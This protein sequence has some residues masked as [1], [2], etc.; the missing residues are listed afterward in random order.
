MQLR[1]IIDHLEKWAPPSLQEN[2]DNSGLILGDKN[3]ECHSAIVSLDVTEEVVDEAIESQ[4]D[5]II[6]HHPLIF[7]GKKRI[8]KTHW[9]DKCLRKAIK[10]DIAIYSIHT[11]LDNINTGVNN[12]IAERIGL[13]QTKILHPKDNTLVKLTVFVPIPDKD[14]LTEALFAAGAGSIG[15]YQ[16]CSFQ[17]IGKGTFK[18][19]DESSPV[20]G[21]KGERETVEEHRIEVMVQKH[22]L[23]KVIEEMKSVHPYEEVAYYASALINRNQEIGSGMIGQLKTPMPTHQFLDHLKSCMEPEV[24]RHTA[25]CK[26]RISKVALCGGAGSFLLETAKAQDADIFI[27]ADFKYHDFFE[28]NNEIIVADIGHY[29]SEVFTKELLRDELSK[30]FANFAFHLSKVDTNPIKYLKH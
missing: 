20:L 2:Y 5:L 29:E 17:Q 11:N 25:L 30:T 10:N 19:N 8:G 16:E 18:G 6:S 22:L 4:S 14:R 27:S 1:E 26:D 21:K 9:I 23:S 7:G 24:I 15:N 3:D 28:A 13:Q 12:K